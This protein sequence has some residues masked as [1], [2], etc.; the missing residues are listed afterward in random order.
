LH[1]CSLRR[2]VYSSPFWM[3]PCLVFQFG[4][5]YNADFIS[6]VPYISILW[7]SLRSVS[8]SFSLKV[9]QNSPENP[10]GP[11]VFLW[12]GDCLLLLQFHYVLYI[13]LLG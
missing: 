13:C 7:I 1:Q 12:G 6:S 9:W 2:L 4:N 5:D 3:C 8:V 11:G 10:S